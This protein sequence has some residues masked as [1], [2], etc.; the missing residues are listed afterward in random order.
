MSLES[1]GYLSFTETEFRSSLAGGVGAEVFE[2]SLEELKSSFDRLVLDPYMQDGGLYR[3]R[4]FGRFR[5][6]ADRNS[7]SALPPAPFV[8]SKENNALNGGVLRWF[9]PLEPSIQ[10]N[11]ALQKMILTLFRRIPNHSEGVWNVF[12]HQVRIRSF[13]SEVGKPTPEGIHQDGHDYVGMVLLERTNVEGGISRIFEKLESGT[14]ALTEQRTLRNC[15]DGFL[16]DDRTVLHEV[17]PICQLDEGKAGHRDMV[18][19]DFNQIS[20]SEAALGTRPVLSL[21]ERIG[22]STNVFDNPK[23][24]VGTVERILNRFSPIE[25]ELEDEAYEAVVQLSPEGYREIKSRLKSLLHGRAN[26]VS[27]HAPYLRIQTNLASSNEAVRQ[28]AVA[29]LK[30]SVQFCHD[31]GGDRVTFHPGFIQPGEDKQTLTENL[32]R[33]IR[34]VS[35]L[36]TPL[37]VLLCIEN[38]GN[39]RPKYLV[40]SAE[41]HLA[42]HA[43]LGIYVTLDLVHLGTWG[44]SEDRILEEVKKY[45]PIT[46]NVHFNDAPEG[47]HR[48]VPL[49]EGILPAQEMMMA[50]VSAGYEGAFVIDEF[51]R[52]FQPELYEQKTMEFKRVIENQN[53]D[54]EEAKNGSLQ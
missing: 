16:V 38:M 32:K 24:I 50:L 44:W 7:L 9:E 31:I 42:L 46:R 34:E 15:L 3:S 11:S 35:E 18:L 25:I 17:T 33:S 47:Q 23:D 36:A 54:Q 37:G 49:G 10:V 26:P 40:Y 13:Q 1:A 21:S 29:L 4:R 48:H 5:V 14:L 12:V 2:T 6:A 30:H 53:A 41:E 43:E 8:Q 22:F 20:A 27:V 19:I 45:A 52:G 28:G 51:A 39:Q